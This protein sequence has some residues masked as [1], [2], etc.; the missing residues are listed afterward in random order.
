MK[1]IIKILFAAVLAYF[2]CDLMFF[3]P[4]P[5]AF[6]A[7]GMAN[8]NP[9]TKVLTV[10]TDSTTAPREYITTYAQFGFDDEGVDFDKPVY[11][12]MRGNSIEC[13][14]ANI[15]LKDQA[16]LRTMVFDMTLKGLLGSF[17]AK[18]IMILLVIFLFLFIVQMYFG[19]YN[20]GKF[21]VWGLLLGIGWYYSSFRAT[22]FDDNSLPH[23]ELGGVIMSYDADGG[24]A[25]FKTMDGSFATY[26]FKSAM[27]KFDNKALALGDTAVIYNWDGVRFLA[28]RDLSEQELT[29]CCNIAK[30]VGNLLFVMFYL[31]CF[32]VVMLILELI[33]LL[34]Q[35]RLQRRVLNLMGQMWQKQADRINKLE[36]D[37][38]KR[39]MAELDRQ[40]KVLEVA[41]DKVEQKFSQMSVDERQGFCLELLSFLVACSTAEFDKMAQTFDEGLAELLQKA[42][43]S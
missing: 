8:Y 10:W 2:V 1:K 7:Y 5:L 9:E 41:L 38:K 35:R 21:V 28:E 29:Y 13:V 4:E 40:M 25:N 14:V 30:K 37:E 43:I 34:F 31:L 32:T 42:N 12:Y 11:L 15:S 16:L 19:R 18:V 36:A 39:V 26:R 27:V 23:R 24:E 17:S 33:G 22:V 3:T 20:R 6:E